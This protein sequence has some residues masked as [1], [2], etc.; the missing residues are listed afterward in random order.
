M[1]IYIYREREREI[2]LCHSPMYIVFKNIGPMPGSKCLTLGVA[3]VSIGMRT[4]SVSLVSKAMDY[5]H[6]YLDESTKM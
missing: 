6:I 5:I 4:L 3:S 2:D 1:H